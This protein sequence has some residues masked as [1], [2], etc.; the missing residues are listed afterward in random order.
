MWIIGVFDHG[1]R[2][3]RTREGV[4]VCAIVLEVVSTFCPKIQATFP[5]I[6]KVGVK[7]YHTRND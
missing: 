3:E 1:E 5:E 7:F 2:R 6:S 4:L